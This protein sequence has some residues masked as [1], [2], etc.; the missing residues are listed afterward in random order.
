MR[1]VPENILLQKKHCISLLTNYHNHSLHK[2]ASVYVKCLKVFFFGYDKFIGVS[3]MLMDLGLPSCNQ[4][5]LNAKTQAEV[6][7]QQICA[8]CQLFNINLIIDFTVLCV[9]V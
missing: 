3:A 5:M 7:S 1:T 4:V 9:S 8:S 2:S 6:L